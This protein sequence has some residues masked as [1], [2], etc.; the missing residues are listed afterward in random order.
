MVK[1]TLM[2]KQ[3]KEKIILTIKKMLELG[4]ISYNEINFIDIEKIP[5]NIVNISSD[6]LKYNE[7][8]TK[9]LSHVVKLIVKD[10]EPFFVDINE[11]FT[12]KIKKLHKASL[13]LSQRAKSLKADVHLKPMPAKERFI[14]HSLLQNEEGIY[15]KSEGEGKNRHIV[16]KY[17]AE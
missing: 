6:D 14:V 1:H 7:N 15:T 12:R 16:I 9:S 10:T 2:N 11:V 4:G 13:I 8:F 17:K 5:T 3:V